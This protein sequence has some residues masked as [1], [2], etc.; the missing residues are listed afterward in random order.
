MRNIKFRAKAKGSPLVQDGTFVYGSL[1]LDCKGKPIIDIQGYV[2]GSGV[3]YE[4]PVDADT[5]GQFTGLLDKNGNEIYEGDILQYTDEKGKNYRREVVYNDGAF[6]Q[7]IK[8]ELF[9]PLRNHDL[10]SWEIIGN[11]HDNHQLMKGQ[12][13]GVENN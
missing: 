11:I 9:T 5:V 1:V 12:D 7:K 10:Q 13:Y 8:F 4:H 6:C 2:D 3:H